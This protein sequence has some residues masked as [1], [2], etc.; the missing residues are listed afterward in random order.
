MVP[1]HQNV[2]N[3]PEPQGGGRFACDVQPVEVVLLYSC[4]EEVR[5]GWSTFCP[6]GYVSGLL[7]YVSVKFKVVVDDD[8]F[9]QVLQ[10]GS[11]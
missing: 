3:V 8:A 5:E 11:G 6:N 10:E 7:V 9:H 2:I 4:H 1:V